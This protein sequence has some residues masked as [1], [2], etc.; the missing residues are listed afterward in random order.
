MDDQEGD[1]VT[2][3]VIRMP[4]HN[5]EILFQPDYWLDRAEELRTQA[6]NLASHGKFYKTLMRH[7]EDC[8]RLAKD[9]MT[10]K[11][12]RSRLARLDRYNF[13]RRRSTD[14]GNVTKLRTGSED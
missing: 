3:S 1:G 7:A 12:T 13:Q 9:A 11:T 6:E 2:E 10:L 8:E 5:Q 4:L 14:V